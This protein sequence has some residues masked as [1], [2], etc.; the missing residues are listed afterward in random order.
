M[1]K[2]FFLL[3]A[4]LSLTE[5]HAASYYTD[6][7]DYEGKI[8]VIKAVIYA[9]TTAADWKTNESNRTEIYLYN[10]ESSLI[11][12]TK[13]EAEEAFKTDPYRFYWVISKTPSSSDKQYYYLSALNG[14]AYIGAASGKNLHTGNYDG[15][16][17]TSTDSYESEFPILAF[18]KAGTNGAKSAYSVVGTSMRFNYGTAGSRWLAV[19]AKG[20]VN[21]TNYTTNVFTNAGETWTTN[22]ELTEVEKTD[23]AGETGS[24]SAPK[25]YGFKLTL[26][27]SDDSYT[28]I[29]GEDHH[30]YATLK[31]P[32]AAG[33]PSEL[34]A[35]T[36]SE[37]TAVS[38]AALTLVKHENKTTSSL[39]GT[40]KNILARETPVVLRMERTGDDADVQ[41]TFYLQPEKAQTITETGFKG[42]LRKATLSGYT[43]ATSDLAYYILTKKNGRVAF[44]PMSNSTINANKAYYVWQPTDS[45]AKPATLSFLFSDDDDSQTTPIQHP[46][47]TDVQSSGSYYDLTGRRVGEPTQKGIYIRNHRKLVVR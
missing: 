3:A 6:P 16:T 46:A 7:K 15:V 19:S 25:H 18:D 22:L 35:Y 21:W 42:S 5:G 43:G 45:E 26:T 17:I 39:D 44:R 36:L 1:R 41:K 2:I 33:L 32:Y 10:G 37:A 8:V 47:A 24:L 30:Y 20:D 11:P 23:V 4:L 14:G 38:N 12:Y 31:L 34:T 27:R 13:T 9:D 28:A 40:Q 29:E